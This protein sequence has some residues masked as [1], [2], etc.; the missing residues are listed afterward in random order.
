MLI[1]AKIFALVGESGS[2]KTTVGRVITKLAQPTGGRLLFD[3][4][5]MT[6]ERGSSALRP[7]PASR[8]DD[9]PGCLSGA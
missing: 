4:R 7:Y 2:G 1:A 8:T 5:D 6:S 9:L 3:G